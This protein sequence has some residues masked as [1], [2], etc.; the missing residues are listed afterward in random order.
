MVGSESEEIG[1]QGMAS[2]RAVQAMTERV[3]FTRVA[4]GF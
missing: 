1:R 2:Q 4:V 3:D